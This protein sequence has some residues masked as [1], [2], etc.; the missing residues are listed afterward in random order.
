MLPEQRRMKINKTK[1]NETKKP[2]ADSW[3]PPPAFRAQRVRGGTPLGLSTRF[4][5]DGPHFEN[6][7]WGSGSRGE[8][9]V[10][11]Q[12]RKL[13]SG[14]DHC[15]PFQLSGGTRDEGCCLHCFW[16]K[17]SCREKENRV[18]LPLSLL[19]PIRRSVC[20]PT[21]PGSWPCRWPHLVVGSPEPGAS[22][23]KHFRNVTDTEEKD[24][25]AP[26][27]T[28]ARAHWALSPQL[29]TG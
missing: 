21:A 5:G 10:R 15:I 13:R 27:V 7:C 14:A 2:H 8:G 19:V 28:S 25:V 16:G 17:S 3:V 6:C 9:E 12:P 24:L 23:S 4:S 18:S 22:G 26:V 11:K 20:P 1:R 29:F